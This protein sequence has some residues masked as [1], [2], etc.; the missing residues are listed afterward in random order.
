[1]ASYHF[2]STRFKYL[3]WCNRII[4][5]I[6]NV[7]SNI[8]HTWWDIYL[9]ALSLKGN[10]GQNKKCFTTTAEVTFFFNNFWYM[11]PYP[12]LKHNYSRTF[13]FFFQT[14]E[15]VPLHSKDNNW[16]QYPHCIV[17]PWCI[18]YKGLLWVYP[19]PLQ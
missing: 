14:T 17:R 12:S 10:H 18:L 4:V 1:M 8:T 15:L 13:I 2:S 9:T 19:Y 5:T 11:K 16:S 7:C 3:L 6:I